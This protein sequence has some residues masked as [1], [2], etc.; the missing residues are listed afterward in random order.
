MVVNGFIEMDSN[1]AGQ[2]YYVF[3]GLAE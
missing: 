1:D 3:P 2:E